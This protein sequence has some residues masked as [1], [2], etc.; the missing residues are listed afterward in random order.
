MKSSNWK[1]WRFLRRGGWVCVLGLVVAVAGSAIAAPKNAPDAIDWDGLLEAAGDVPPG[2]A[3]AFLLVQG[4]Q[5]TYGPFRAE[6][7]VITGYPLV[8]EIRALLTE[9]EIEGRMLTKAELSHVLDALRK[10]LR[11]ETDIDIEGLAQYLAGLGTI[12]LDF[13]DL[14]VLAEAV[15][16]DL[17]A[18][19][20]RTAITRLTEMGLF[21]QEE[22]QGL[23]AMFEEHGL[24]VDE[25]ARGL[26]IKAKEMGLFAEVTATNLFLFMVNHDLDLSLIS[27]YLDIQ[28][29]GRYL[30]AIAK[31]SGLKID[32][33]G[34]RISMDERD[35]SIER[36]SRQSALTVATAPY[37]P[38]MSWYIGPDPYFAAR[39]KHVDMVD[40][41]VNTE[42]HVTD[43]VFFI[44]PPEDWK[45]DPQ[46]IRART[47]WGEIRSRDGAPY[48]VLHMPVRK[49]ADLDFQ[50]TLPWVYAM[51][52]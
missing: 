24:F 50:R 10:A 14:I 32:I 4:G 20:G 42:L 38:R 35:L 1:P 45:M 21:T 37:A 39:A 29:I 17:D 15:G 13:A 36:T 22:A 11:L 43:M 26:F 27:R 46:K 16:I 25:T 8:A 6:W 9:A 23:F 52:E 34:L 48:G 2:A 3:V 19:S 18:E 40:V 12:K 33:K 30:D 51:T 49:E 28:V 31:A 5:G 41:I 47:G 44:F 7:P